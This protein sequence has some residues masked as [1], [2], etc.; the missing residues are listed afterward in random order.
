MLIEILEDSETIN[1]VKLIEVDMQLKNLNTEFKTSGI[2]TSSVT[3]L[4]LKT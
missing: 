4:E 2:D 1:D 3:K